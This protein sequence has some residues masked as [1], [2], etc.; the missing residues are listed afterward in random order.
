MRV[1]EE[2]RREGNLRVVGFLR[3]LFGQKESPVEVETELVVPERADAVL[4]VVGEQSYQDT[5]LQIAGGRDQNGPKNPRHHAAL[6]PEPTNKYDRNAICVR[7]DGQRVGYLSRED[8]IRYGPVTRWIGQRGLVIGCEAFLKGGWYRGRGDVGSVGVSLHLGSP[9]ETMLQLLEEPLRIRNDHPWRGVMIAFTG[10]SRCTWNG[11]AID[12][13]LATV[14]A[15]RAGMIVHPRVTKKVQML[16]DCDPGG[17]SG[18]ELKAH[19]YG[20]QVIL[21]ADF[22]AALGLATEVLPWQPPINRYR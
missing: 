20:I 14:I 17:T 7:I 16:V 6:I 11:M 12:R 21:E 9:G 4:E 5:I 19:E 18:N 22:W 13:E 1:L 15:T 10:D 8:A 2:G 3:T